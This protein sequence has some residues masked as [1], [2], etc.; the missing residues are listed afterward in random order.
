ML[1]FTTVW[2]T[3]GKGKVAKW[4]SAP[5]SI[6]EGFNE[7]YTVYGPQNPVKHGENAKLPH[8]P[9]FAPLQ[10][11]LLKRLLLKLKYR[12]ETQGPSERRSGSLASEL[13]T[14]TE[15]RAR[16]RRINFE[17]TYNKEWPRYCRK[18]YWTKMVQN[19]QNDHFGQED[20]IPN[21]ILAF[22]RPKWTKMVHFGP[23]WP[24]EVYFGRLRSVEDTIFVVFSAKHSFVDMKE[25]TLIKNKNL[26]KI[27]VVCQ[28][29]KRSFFGMF[30]F[31]FLVVLF[32]FCL[33]FCSCVL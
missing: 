30:F 21:W 27:V 28:N 20:L 4:S 9:V 26:P 23:F 22:A 16:K 19:G 13:D 7:I 6:L 5:A 18:A 11:P 8:R 33:C 29:A 1:C 32:F 17:H 24:K 15:N 14:G 25:C 2:D 10:C 12:E 3:P 31:C